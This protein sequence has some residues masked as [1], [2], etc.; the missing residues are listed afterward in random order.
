MKTFVSVALFSAISFV[1]AGQTPLAAQ[2]IQP[3]DKAKL[4]CKVAGRSS[5]M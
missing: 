1:A 5:T 2:S 3:E 4:L